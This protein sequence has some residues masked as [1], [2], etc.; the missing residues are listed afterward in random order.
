MTCDNRIDKPF[1]SAEY[2]NW[3]HHAAN[4]D[5]AES[6]WRPSETRGFAIC[7]RMVPVTKTTSR[8]FAANRLPPPDAK[9]DPAETKRNKPKVP[10]RMRAM[11]ILFRVMP[12]FWRHMNS[13]AVLD[14][15]GIFLHQQS[16]AMASGATV[17]LCLHKLFTPT[18]LQSG[19]ANVGLHSR[20]RFVWVSGLQLCGMSAAVSGCGRCTGLF[21]VHDVTA[22]SL[23][24]A[25]QAQ[26]QIGHGSHATARVCR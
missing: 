26:T 10:L 11:R 3:A 19:M 6:E 20:A 15:D 1:N 9:Q 25:R 13:L 21:R 16:Q 17:L 12:R 2:V 5:D 22:S 18:Q 23:G 4:P 24:Q 8:I 14:G 7:I